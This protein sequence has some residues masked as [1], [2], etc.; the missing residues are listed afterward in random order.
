VAQRGVPHASFARG[1]RVNLMPEAIQMGSG[2]AASKFDPETSLYYYRA[3][4]YDQS[5]GRF[6]NED[7]IGLYAG[8]NFYN[9]SVNSPVN[10]RDATGL[11]P[12]CDGCSI[13]VSCLPTHGL[14]FTHCTVTI[15]NGSTYTAYDGYP[16]GNWLRSQLLVQGG[17][18]SPPGKD[19]FFTASIDCKSKDC[20]QKAVDYINNHNVTYSAPTVNSNT[21]AWILTRTCG[22]HPTFPGWAWGGN[23]D[24][25][26]Q[27]LSGKGK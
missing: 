21:A 11:A 9:Y 27:A 7:P 25:A 6:L 15:R 17:T 4:Y 16:S 10:F 18:G 19:T 2:D 5:V 1:F 20:A 12:D 24:S 8:V 26:R 14:D 22:V 23:Y 3:R 13:S